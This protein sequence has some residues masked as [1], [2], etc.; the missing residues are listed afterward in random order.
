MV[1][2]SMQYRFH[3]FCENSPHWAGS[4]IYI[5]VCHNEFQVFLEVFVNFNQIIGSFYVSF[6]MDDCG[7]TRFMIMDSVSILKWCFSTSLFSYLRFKMN[8][9]DPSGLSLMNI[10][11]M[12]SP[13]SCW[14]DL[15]WINFFLFFYSS[16]SDSK[17]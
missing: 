10:G 2:A 14:Q 16:V 6:V 13:I 5:D 1:N 8:L 7:S 12:T 4:C 17:S 11:E 9:D 3:H 15:K